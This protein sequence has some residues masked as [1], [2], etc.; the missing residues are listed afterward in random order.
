[1]R[2]VGAAVPAWHDMA[3]HSEL[4]KGVDICLRYRCVAQHNTA[5]II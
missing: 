2:Q 3:L 5:G 1:L 4:F